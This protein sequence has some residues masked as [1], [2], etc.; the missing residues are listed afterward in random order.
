MSDVEMD[1]EGE[2][3]EFRGQQFSPFPHVKQPC[4]TIND[5]FFQPGAR[6]PS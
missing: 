2:F 4:A 5:D 1:S 3:Q 6:Q